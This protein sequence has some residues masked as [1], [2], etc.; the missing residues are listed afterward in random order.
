MSDG[1]GL[2]AV[3]TG[4]AS[5][6]G[7]ALVEECERRG[8]RVF[9][10]DVDA[11]ARGSVVDVGSSADVEAFARSVYSQTDAVDL[12]FNNAGIMASAP[13]VDT[14][15]AIW[16]RLLGVNLY[17]VLNVARAFVPHMRRQP[18]RGRIVNTASM[19]GFV[20]PYGHGN[21]A[22]AATKAAVVSVSES[23]V[24]ELAPDG[25]AVSVVCP[26]GVATNIF[27]NPDALPPDLMRPEEAATR[28]LEGV[29]AG[30]FY[31]FTHTDA[32]AAERLASRWARVDADFRAAAGAG[33]TRPPTT[34][35]I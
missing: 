15:D 34:I 33:P 8:M 4:G 14:T 5:G 12:L 27:G 25:V 18:R 11:T 35:Q 31:V 9:A 13:I 2:V 17:G 28:I 16:S 10:A 6:I 20:P 19:A 3:V 24:H 7:R 21:G 32:D 29:L 22:Y 1:A 30:R 23:L 26:S